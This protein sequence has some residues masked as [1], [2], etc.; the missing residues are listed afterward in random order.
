MYLK[1]KHTTMHIQNNFAHLNFIKY[2]IKSLFD[3]RILIDSDVLYGL[4]HFN[5]I[6][7]V[8]KTTILYSSV[9]ERLLIEIK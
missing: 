7:F 9:V 8:A 3:F 5:D 6:K 2:G 4:N 1:F